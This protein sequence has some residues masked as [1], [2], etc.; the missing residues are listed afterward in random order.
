MERKVGEEFCRSVLWIS[1]GDKCC[2]EGLRSSVGGE[3]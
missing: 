1:V 2:R 3:N